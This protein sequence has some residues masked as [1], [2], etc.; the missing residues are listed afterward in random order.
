MTP[1][2]QVGSRIAALR[3]ER[4]WSRQQ[5]AKRAGI[6]SR[7][8]ADVEAG[9]GNIALSRL[10][11]LCQALET[12]L[13][14][15]ATSLLEGNEASNFS[16]TTA[17]QAAILMALQR[18]DEQELNEA[19]LWFSQRGD[20]RRKPIAL[21]GL[22]GAGKTTIGRKVAAELR[23]PFLELDE[24]IERHAG[25]TL[26]NVFEF[27]GEEYYRNLEHE[28]LEGLLSELKPAVLA[29]GGGIVTRKD[30]YG[31]VRAHCHA[32]WL[33]ADPRD[34]WNRVLH[35]DPR[36]MANYPDAF[37][38]LQNILVERAPL[39]AQA[40]WTIDTTKLGVA[41]SVEQIV[42]SVPGSATSPEA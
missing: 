24:L 7:F 28:V 3:H 16:K 20:S 22:R 18:C 32:F 15:L 39:Y 6:S 27:H 35:Q 5:L 12:P 17:L 21:I 14:L 41:G 2:Q 38:Q 40:H 37:A 31:L 10:V 36:P 8:L 30:T 34:H 4:G 42:R 25:L 11:D 19:L 26:T 23:H 29:T 9:N 1:L 33:K 13:S